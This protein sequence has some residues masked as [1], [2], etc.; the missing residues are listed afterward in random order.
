MEPTANSPAPRTPPS[1]PRADSAPVEPL[2][3][4][5][6]PG[7][8]YTVMLRPA[9]PSPATALPPLQADQQ[10]PDIPMPATR[11]PLPKPM[12]K[13]SANWP[14]I[15]GAVL[16][17]LLTALLIAL[18]KLWAI[19]YVVDLP[20]DRKTSAQ[21]L[22]EAPRTDSREESSMSVT[23]EPMDDEPIL[24]PSS[25]PVLEEL[26]DPVDYDPQLSAETDA[27]R[28]A[29]LATQSVKKTAPTPAPATGLTPAPALP[30]QHAE[31]QQPIP[32]SP[33]LA[34]QTVRPVPSDPVTVIGSKPASPA[35]PRSAPT[36]ATVGSLI[37]AVQPWA[38]IWV[39][40]RKRGIS[41]PL[42]KLQLPPGLYTVE[43]RNPDLPSYSQKVQISTGQSVTLRH[44]FQ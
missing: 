36:P 22:A 23:Q 7:T 20:A 44:S 2:S 15:G 18:W 12:A 19:D 16:S 38:E 25:A 42:F 9:A 11:L 24:P 1:T 41:P 43:L 40:G 10:E 34:A 26:P 4:W 29:P 35:K 32:T 13:P 8:A 5:D 37:V 27:T 21:P 39:D 3:S 31:H 6:G 28:Q 14:L 17:T 33:A 30:Q